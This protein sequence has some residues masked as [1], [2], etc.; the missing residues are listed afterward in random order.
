ML[1]NLEAGFYDGRY[2]TIIVHSS[3]HPNVFEKV[4]SLAN[5]NTPTIQFKNEHG[6]RI[7]LSTVYKKVT[8]WLM[9]GT[10]L[11]ALPSDYTS[12]RLFFGHNAVLKAED[13]DAMLPWT[14]A[15]QIEFDISGWSKPEEFVN[16]VRELKEENNKQMRKVEIWIP[17]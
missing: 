14:L 5:T 2:D 15:M 3:A 1:A 9:N 8:A 7:E 10:Q 6:N 4:K 13:V 11:A 17:E 12:Y 16:R